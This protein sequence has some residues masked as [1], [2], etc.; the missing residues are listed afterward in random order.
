[1]LLSYAGRVISVVL[2]T[3]DGAAFVGEQVRSI[4]AQ[5]PEPDELVLGDDASTDDTVRLIE[6]AV[7][8]HRAAGGVT[9]LVVRRH[10]PAL[11]VVA[12][13]A[14]GLA[15][16]RGDL[17]AL[18]DQDDIW[19]PGK[20]AAITA[21]FDADPALLLVHTDARLI[22]GSGAPTGLTLLQ[23]L[24]ATPGERA[25]LQRGDAF[26]TLLRRNLVTGATVVL[27]RDLVAAA[28][29]F[30]EA[31][32]HDEWLAAI[33]AARDALRLLAD[34]LID[35]RQHGGNQIGARRPTMADRWAKLR[36]PREP[37][38]SRLVARN[39]ALVAALERLGDSIPPRNLERARARLAHE[40]RRRALP[41]P[42]VARLPKIVAAA[43]RGDY[44]RYSRGP[45]DVLRDLVQPS[46][47]KAPYTLNR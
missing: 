3:H 14:D 11:G 20:L 10:D 18:S 44:S 23:A 39:E 28:A 31:W 12:N 34:P 8:D 47:R 27:R 16:A 21:A 37:R 15:H 9:E 42:N 40:R 13:F 45:S 25:G 30:P 26:G 24:E 4:L 46:P 5:I 43:L 35:Y 19:S 41:R 7:T 38:A 6:R 33:A 17:V 32:V 36:E 1:V 29:P 2:C 22:D